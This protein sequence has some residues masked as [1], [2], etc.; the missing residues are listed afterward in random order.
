MKYRKSQE[1]YEKWQAIIAEGERHPVS[2]PVPIVERMEL[3]RPITRSC[4]V[5]C[6]NNTM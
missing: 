2:T 3:K 1:V 5:S 4:E 6:A